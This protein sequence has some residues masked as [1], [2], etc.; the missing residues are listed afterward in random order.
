VSKRARTSTAKHPRPAESQAYRPASEDLE[1][2]AKRDLRPLRLQLELLKPEW[3]F[4]QQDVR[5]TIVVFGS[6]RI[7]PPEVAGA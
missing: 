7:L 1:V 5:S 4:R 2:L 3:Y 6:A